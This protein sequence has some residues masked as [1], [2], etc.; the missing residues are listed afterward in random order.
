MIPYQKELKKDGLF[1]K[2]IPT[3]ERT[4]EQCSLAVRQNPKALKYVP[5]KLQTVALCK[6]AMKRDPTVFSM[7]ALRNMS[8]K[9][10]L[11]AVKLDGMNLKYVDD[12][13][14]T[15][16]VYHAAVNNTIKALKYVPTEAKNNIFLHVDNVLL[17]RCLQW[18]HEDETAID[19]FPD[20]ES[21]LV[22]CV[23]YYKIFGMEAIGAFAGV[24][25]GPENIHF[26]HDKLL[27]EQNHALLNRST[28]KLKKRFMIW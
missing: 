12:R 4:P 18:M 5:C 26:F 11:Y 10:S 25:D 23:P 9:L 6:A 24:L 3:K 14:Q 2:R 22:L 13:Y 27:Q 28:V 1:L 8:E 7:I 17:D 15:K 19:F 20:S 16:A 21:C